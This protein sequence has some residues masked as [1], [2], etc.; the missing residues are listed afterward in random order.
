[1]INSLINY[2][3]QDQGHLARGYVNNYWKMSISL[4]VIL[5]CLL[6]MLYY[7]P[8]YDLSILHGLRTSFDI[9]TIYN[10]LTRA[11]HC[12]QIRHVYT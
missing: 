5:L 3:A 2:C 10:D 11:L 7:L 12:T 1:M 4:I 8:F 9:H 6:M